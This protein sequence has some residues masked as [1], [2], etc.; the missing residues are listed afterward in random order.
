MNFNKRIKY[1][2]LALFMIGSIGVSAQVSIGKDSVARGVLDVNNPQGLSNT[3]GIVLPKVESVSDV[4][5]GYENDT[6][7]P[8]TLVYDMTTHG[9]RMKTAKHGWT[10]P[11]LDEA[12]FNRT[13]EKLV[14]VGGN[15]QV[16]FAA[17]GPQHTLCIGQDDRAVYAAGINSNSRT[18]IGRRASN[19]S[20]FTLIF[21]RRVVD[22]A[23]GS[24]HSA[25][26]DTLGQLWTWGLD[27]SYRTGLPDRGTGVNLG[28]SGNT[29]TPTLVTTYNAT[30]SYIDTIFGRK[31][32]N[33]EGKASR[34][35]FAVQ[36]EI[37]TTNTYVLTD[38]GKVYSVGGAMG[39]TT[40]GTGRGTAASATWAEIPFSLEAGDSIVQISA[41]GTTAGAVS[42]RG[43]LYTWGVGSGYAVGANGTATSTTSKS[44]PALVT[45]PASDSVYMVA[46][47]TRAS[48]AI[49]YDRK[50]LYV[51]GAANKHGG[52]TTNNQN[53]II[54]NNFPYL[55][56]TDS[57]I[58]VAAQRYG[59]ATADGG[60][61]VITTTGVYGTGLNTS[62]QVGNNTV[63]NLNS[64]WAPINMTGIPRGT[65]F[66]TV[67]RGTATTI[68]TTGANI[69]AD[70]TSMNN[71]AYGMGAVGAR[72]LGAILTAPRIP[73]QL[74]K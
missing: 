23:A 41:S 39:T 67:A 33:A 37:S 49:S 12:G 57:I 13:V 21:A 45:M 40:A 70:N 74:T 15:F 17:I 28:N 63:T 24:S 53:P 72:Q 11:L 30:E 52:L 42:K 51:W 62:G 38:D 65:V 56:P 9:V 18:G 48:A 7:I 71:V 4:V 27:D 47:G 36:V 25:A 16:K 29:S 58:Y 31:V 43:R 44:T 61:Q 55:G 50:R 59:V 35:G 19:M 2:F 68:L 46:M 69:N 1:L 26:V 54:A 32:A 14:G 6:V 34:F 22:V 60:L 20:T 73:Q 66:T 3:W 64:T 10:G 8:G 5:S